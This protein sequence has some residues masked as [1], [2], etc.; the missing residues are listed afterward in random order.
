MT[1]TQPLA[2]L[3]YDEVLAEL[4]EIVSA[5]PGYVYPAN[6]R[7]FPRYFSRHGQPSCLVGHWLHR[8][9]ITPDRVVEHRLAGPTVKDLGL[10][11]RH[12][13]YLLDAAQARQDAGYPWDRALQAAQGLA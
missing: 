8:H 9:G 2:G 4:Q 10:T 13:I 1:D 11:D 12:A 7:V 3:T 5:N 6:A